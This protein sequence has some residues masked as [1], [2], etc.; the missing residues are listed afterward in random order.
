V[1]MPKI[2]NHTEMPLEIIS[3]SCCVISVT[4]PESYFTSVVY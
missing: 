2:P 1:T 4:V 3:L